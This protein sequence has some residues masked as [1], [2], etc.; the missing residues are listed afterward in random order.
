MDHTNGTHIRRFLQRK[1]ALQGIPVSGT[2][3]LTPRCNL[4]CRMCYIRLSP[5]EMHQIGRELT[6]DEWLS[7]AAAARDAGMV[8]LLLTGGEPTLRDDFPALYSELAGMGLSISI[9]TNGTCLSPA[10]K[11]AWHKSPPAQ[12]N[13]TLY[14]TCRDDYASLC[15]NPAACENVFE[16]LDWLRDENILVHLNTTMTPYNVH[17]I[18]ELENFAK[19]RELELRVTSY[20]FPPIRRSSCDDQCTFARLSP[21]EAARSAVLDT[22]Y[23]YGINGIRRNLADL[24]KGIL[25]PCELDIGEP[26]RCMAGRGQFWVTWDGRML[27][28][29]MLEKPYARPFESSFTEAWESLRSACSQIRL[30]PECTN[31]SSQKYCLNCAAVT[32]T[33]T[34]HF[35]GKPEYMCRMT[36]AYKRILQEFAENPP[37]I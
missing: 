35:D 5:A 21:E 30:C 4:F 12:V 14:G 11:K 1:C 19:E 10:I 23:Q 7:L 27:P 2:F 20:C 13:I 16:T 26:I 17:R 32:Y 8:F 37:E 22:F 15:G 31:C 18:P 25:N 29:G 3:E 33:E 34:G 28:C 9:N 24:E 6:M 36:R